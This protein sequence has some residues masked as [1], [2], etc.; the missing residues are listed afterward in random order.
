MWIL[1]FVRIVFFIYSELKLL[2]YPRVSTANIFI[3]VYL[4]ITCFFLSTLIQPKSQFFSFFFLLFLKLNSWPLDGMGVW[5]ERKQ[6]LW[7]QFMLL[8][9]THLGHNEII[10]KFAK[11]VGVNQCSSLCLGDLL[12]D[13]L[14]RSL[15]GLLWSTDY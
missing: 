6:I 8:Y 5:D 11:A 10:Q 7:N 2:V 4:I 15:P 1:G 12:I 14:N 9:G 13:W 3:L